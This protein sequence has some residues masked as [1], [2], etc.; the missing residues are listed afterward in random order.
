MVLLPILWIISEILYAPIR[1]V[2][3]LASF[4]TYICTG[5]YDMFG[6]IQLFLS[7]VFQVAS[8]SEA[9]VSA[10]EVSVWRTLWN[11]LFSQVLHLK[12]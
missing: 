11:D 4:I 6:D 12:Q 2:L 8:V 10:S 5:I 3:S 7:S 1:A 9:T